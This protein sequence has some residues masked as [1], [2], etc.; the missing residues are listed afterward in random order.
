ML[1]TIADSLAASESGAIR[2]VRIDDRSLVE[3]VLRGAGPVLDPA[4]ATVD[5]TELYLVDWHV[6]TGSLVISSR[7]AVLYCLA[8]RSRRPYLLFHRGMTVY[9]P[10][11]GVEMVNVG[12]VGDIYD[13]PVVL[14]A[15]SACS[16]SFLFGS[17]RCN[18]HHQWECVQELAAHSNPVGTPP[19][20]SGHDFE[21]WVQTQVSVK[22]GRVRFATGGRGFVMLHLDCQNGMGSGHT[23]GEF[24]EDLYT[25][26]SMRH[27]GEYASEQVFGASMAE[28]FTTLG[29]EPDPRKVDDSIGYQTPFIVLDTLGINNELQFLSNNPRKW[30][31]PLAAPYRIV[32]V[33]LAGEVNLAGAEEAESR[34]AEFGHVG[35]GSLVGFD[36]EL[37]RLV[38]ELKL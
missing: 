11:L 22:G 23:R 30:I 19:A 32:P 28:A 13:A 4:L 2:T 10:G 3:R 27:R 1:A 9:R 36:E 25:R 12:L 20:A 35:I 31:H 8:P 6:P 5:L 18:C 15:E 38:G 14:R 26:A 17:Q 29:L 7:G 21:R 24:V 33:S 34:N 16:P 37:A